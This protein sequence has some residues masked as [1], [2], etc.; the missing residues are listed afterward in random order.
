MVGHYLIDQP[1]SGWENMAADQRMLEI[2]AE[3][4][5]PLLRIYAWNRPTLSLGYFQKYADR[6][7]HPASSDIETRLP[8]QNPSKTAVK[9]SQA[10]L[11]DFCRCKPSRLSRP[12]LRTKTIVISSAVENLMLLST[13]A[14]SLKLDLPNLR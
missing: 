11:Q 4:A 8:D 10:R 1:R 14:E 12:A 2:A 3:C 6:L 9:I 7:T 13:G 5:Q